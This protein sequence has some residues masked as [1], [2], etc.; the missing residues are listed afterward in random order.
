M[1][2]IAEARHARA[3]EFSTSSV[4]KPLTLRR[5]H[6]RLS[7]EPDGQVRFLESRRE[8]RLVFGRDQIQFF[9]TQSG[10]VMHAQRPDWKVR[11]TPSGASFSVRLFDSVEASQKI[12]FLPGAVEGYSRALSLKNVGRAPVRLSML[13]LQDPTAAHFRENRFA[14]GALGVNAFNRSSH[15]AMDEVADSPAARVVGGRPSPKLFYMTTDRARA[16]DLLQAGDLPESTAGM[17]GQVLVLSEFVFELPIG[18]SSELNLVSVYDP[19]KLEG[20]L[21]AFDGLSGSLD[22][23]ETDP[24]LAASSSPAVS[25]AASWARSALQGMEAEPDPLERFETLRGIVY[26]DAGAAKSIVEEAKAGLGKSGFLAHSSS[27]TAPGLLETSTFL[28]GACRVALLSPEKKYARLLYP[29]A[30]KLATFLMSS[31]GDGIVVSDPALPQGWRRRIGKGYPT[32]QIPEV[33][34]SLSGALSLAATLASRLG[35]GEESARWAERAKVI[36]ASV[37]SKMLDDHG[38]LSLCVVGG[39]LRI[40][41]TV[42]QAVACYRDVF[43][44]ATASSEVHRLIEK[45]FESGWG[46]RTVPNTNRTYFNS[47]Y[48]EGQL[49]G[50]WTRA[51]LAHTV[52]AYETGL[53][54]IGSIELESIAK[55]PSLELVRLGG[56]PGEFPYWVDL[57][58]RE[59]HGQG[60]DPVAASR[61]IEALV[62]GEIGYSPGPGG[63][64]FDPS[65]SSQLR[66]ILLSGVYLGKRTSVFVGRAHGRAYTFIALADARVER[67]W[68]FSGAELAQPHDARLSSVSFFGPGQAVCVGNESGGT[69]RNSVSFKPRDPALSKHLSV[70][71]E[72]LDPSTGAWKKASTVRVL[73]SMSLEVEL[74]PSEWKAFRIST[75]Y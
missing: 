65:P 40:E 69:V 62:R 26:V 59:A 50:Y 12:R 30:R 24:F 6:Q 51:A 18:G 13:A 73:T 9:K 56:A 57:Q 43:D 67:G 66:W 75:S 21:S 71:L 19:S 10:I 64:S 15:V 72:E 4:R 61:F 68:K 74:G 63:H 16:E 23:V 20:A 42:D 49:G 52:L 17:S 1:G 25:T 34:L 54:G 3:D 32:G 2:A 31:S 37:K 41:E 36:R 47:S 60:S 29:T 44:R 53:A 14:W 5:A 8:G 11:L 46:P 55:L 33:S 45:D 28:E 22:E 35:K 58:R 70:G 38:F 48:G 27:R 7:I 39:K